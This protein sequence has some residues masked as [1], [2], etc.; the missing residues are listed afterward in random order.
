MANLFFCSDH[1][2]G[3]DLLVG[4]RGFKSAE[5]MNELM[6]ER[7]NKVI[8]PSDHV[9]F[10][11]DVAINKKFLWLVSRMN[12]KK[13]LIFG[14]HDIFDYQLYADAGFKKLMSYRVLDGFICSHIPIYREGLKR[15]KCNIHGHTH[16]NNV[17]SMMPRYETHEAIEY[18]SVCVEQ[19]NY[20][21]ISFEDIK[22][23]VNSRS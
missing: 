19:I 4:I 5:E 23:K 13:R 3:H 11:G 17:K 21:P 12:G 7:H 10:L 22:K 14:N 8:G 6:I 18:F 15:F 9:Y 16:E 1:H 2:F 20:T